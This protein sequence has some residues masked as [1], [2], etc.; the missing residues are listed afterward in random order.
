[1]STPRPR[2][3]KVDRHDTLWYKVL[4][5]WREGL[6]SRDTLTIWENGGMVYAMDFGVMVNTVRQ[7]LPLPNWSTREEIL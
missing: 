1:M 3:K 6:R 7:F 5:G 2:K 4:T